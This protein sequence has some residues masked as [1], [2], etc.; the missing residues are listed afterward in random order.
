[1]NVCK[2]SNVPLSPGRNPGNTHKPNNTRQRNIKSAS[3]DTPP[4]HHGNQEARTPDFYYTAALPFNAD[5]LKQKPA[6]SSH[7]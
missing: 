3:N 2:F 1:M 6:V 5:V 4:P 7:V